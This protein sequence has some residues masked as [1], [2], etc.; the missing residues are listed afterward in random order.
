MAHHDAPLAL[1][2]AAY[3]DPN[4]AAGD[5]EE[6]KRMARDKLITV[7]GLV[8]VSRDADGKIDVKDKAGD[9]GK[10][11]KLGAVGGAVV[12]LIFPPAF[13]ASALVGAGVGAGTGKLVDHH[14]KK[15]IKEDVE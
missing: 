5:W 6:I 11:T 14:H 9:V 10:G 1:Y 15:E 4:A 12:G 8:L 13:L 7:D 2:I 3:A